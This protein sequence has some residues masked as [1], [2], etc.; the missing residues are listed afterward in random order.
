MPFEFARYEIC[1]FIRLRGN[2]CSLSH[3]RNKHST[4]CLCSMFTSILKLFFMFDGD[5]YWILLDT[6]LAH[7]Q[8]RTCLK[9]VLNSIYFLKFEC[10][11]GTCCIPIY[12]HCSHA[13]TSFPFQVSYFIMQMKLLEL[14]FWL[15]PSIR[16]VIH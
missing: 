2:T 12:T 15:C 10:I 4:N 3:F 13:R 5:T 6:Y 16:H 9:H 8:L 7:S 1:F 11:S 14:Q